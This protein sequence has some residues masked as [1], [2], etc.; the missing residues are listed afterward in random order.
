MKKYR[1]IPLVEVKGRSL[2]GNYVETK[3]HIAVNADRIT[4]IIPIFSEKQ[5]II[6]VDGD[7]DGR[8]VDIDFDTLVSMLNE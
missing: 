6:F 8:T 2:N 7:G 1:F 3:E 5:C 4:H